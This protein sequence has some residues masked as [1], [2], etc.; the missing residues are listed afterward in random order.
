MQQW[1]NKINS[2]IKS[3]HSE[4]FSLALLLYYI[5]DAFT[6]E[7]IA[8]PT[9]TNA[10]T[11][12]VSGMGLIEAIKFFFI[13]FFGNTNQLG[14]LY[15]KRYYLGIGAF[16]IIMVTSEAVYKLFAPILY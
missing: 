7:N 4:A 13:G 15:Q 5:Y 3:H 9:I 1:T 6:G 8:K 14:P 16:V 10:V 12:I 11:I 2:A